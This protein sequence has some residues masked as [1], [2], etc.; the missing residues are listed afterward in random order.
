MMTDR[1][2][3]KKLGESTCCGATVSSTN[4]TGCPP[5]SNPRLRLENS[6]SDSLKCGTTEAVIL[7]EVLDYLRVLV[8]VVNIVLRQMLQ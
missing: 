7:C 2:K 8:F 1:G 3:P 4:M 6:A 5:V